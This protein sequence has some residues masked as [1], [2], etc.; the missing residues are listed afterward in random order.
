M[1][2]ADLTVGL[3][4][5]TYTVTVDRPTTGNAFTH[6]ACGSSGRPRT[7]ARSRRGRMPATGG[8]WAGD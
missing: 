3:A 1:S 8:E 2:I 7:R 4:A 5:G 6:L